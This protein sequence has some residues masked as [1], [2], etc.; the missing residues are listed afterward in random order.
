MRSSPGSSRRLLP[1]ESSSVSLSVVIPVYNESENILTTLQELDRHV[2]E[3]TDVYVIYDFDEDTTLTVLPRFQ[4]QRLRL[5]P[6]K[7]TY[8]RGALNAIKFGMDTARS[9]A[10]LV[11]M[12]DLS[13]DLA[14]L[15]PMLTQIHSGASDLVC[16]SRYMPGGR[17]IGGPVLKKTLSR[18]AGVS[19]FLLAGIP[20]H[21]VTNSFKLYSRRVLD[22][23]KVES[24]GGFEIGMEIVVKAWIMG[25]KV[26]ELPTTWRDRAAGESRFQLWNWI[27]KYLRWYFTAMRYGLKRRLGIGPCG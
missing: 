18:V 10:V 14:N 11:M 12:A 1:D 23:I 27:P 4:G 9:E 7:N 16:G 2:P 21:D 20:T 25:F 13:D 19:L 26:T 6:T 17:H 15:K 22:A 24:I 5:K 8:G 3:A